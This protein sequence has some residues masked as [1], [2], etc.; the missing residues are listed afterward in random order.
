M[1]TCFSNVQGLSDKHEGCPKSLLQ[2]IMDDVDEIVYVSDVATYELLY[3]NE[4]GKKEFGLASIE[5]GRKCYE[6]LQGLDAPCPFCTNGLLNSETFYTWE[7]TNPIS[8]RHYLLRDKL[9][10]WN[11]RLVRLEFAVDITEKENISQAVQRKLD[12]ESTLLECIRILNREEDFPQ[13]V[14]M[15]L[16]N[17]GMMHQADRAYIFEYSILKNGELIANNTYEWCS[18]G[19]LPQKDVLQNV[20]FSCIACWQKMFEQR[21]DVVI[22]SLEAIRDKDSEMY[23]TL[24][25]QGIDS[26]IVVPL[27]L[28]DI[29]S[30]FIGV[31]NPKANKDDH[32]LL[33]SLAY[34]VTNEQRKRNMQS[35]LKRM[36]FC[37]DLTGLHNRNSYISVLQKLEKRTPNSL[38]VVFVDLNG[39][40]RI[41]DQYGHDSGDKYIRDISRIFSRHFRGDD[42]FRI[43]GDEFVFLCPNIPER[44]FHTKVAALQRDANKAYP[45]SLSLGKVWAEGKVHT[46]DMVKLADQLM[47]QE[48]AKYHARRGD[49]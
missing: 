7:I 6:V 37:D 34:F 23:S 8:H 46:M 21:E 1:P 16:E 33:H 11:D 38:G 36:S 45:E 32:S 2:I 41:N 14:E 30:G 27:V 40:K 12:I 22:D 3:L 35:E 13:A 25:P 28:N 43:G 44:V 17:L 48:K 24:K 20:P 26:L 18:E 10:H 4:F 29:I 42:L 9:I 39:L 47:Y 15:V 19:I 49:T 5:G 31:D